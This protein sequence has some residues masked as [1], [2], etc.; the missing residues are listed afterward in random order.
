MSNDPTPEQKSLKYCEDLGLNSVYQEALAKRSALGDKALEIT[1]LRNK[2]RNLESLKTDLEMEVIENERAAHP[3]MSAAQMDKHL[4]VAFSNNCDLRDAKE[5]IN[6][7]TT[8]IDVV[9]H[10]IELLNIDIR[11]ATARLN[12]L[13]GYF[14]FMAIIKS[15]NEAKKTHEAKQNESQSNDEGNPWK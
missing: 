7:V 3:E 15:I 12:E 5:A 13:G 2:K 1:D 9:E 4:K 10:E 11:I 8:Q 14:Q 6:N